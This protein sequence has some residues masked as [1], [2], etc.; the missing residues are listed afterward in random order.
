MKRPNLPSI[1][2]FIWIGIMLALAGFLVW[3]TAPSRAQA[4]DRGWLPGKW[5]R[6]VYLYRDRD[7]HPRRRRSESYY[8]AA[9][10]PA[11]QARCFGRLFTDKG[12][13]FSSE[14]A[15]LKDAE[16]SWGALVREEPGEKWM[17]L[18]FAERYESRCQRSS[19]GESAAAKVTDT[20]TGGAYGTLYRCRIWAE[21]CT[22]PRT[23][24]GGKDR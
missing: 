10:S 15:A 21:P 2:A 6:H 9:E 23:S 1:E 24:D 17:D 3:I 22:A 13:E 4:Q 8:R 5:E 19:T 11:L 14:E 20:L 18:K 12:R 7:H 16:R